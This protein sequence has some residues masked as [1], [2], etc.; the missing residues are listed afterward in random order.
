MP[1]KKYAIGVDIGGTH[2]TSAAVDLEKKMFVAD[3]LFHHKVNAHDQPDPILT[4]W[5]STIQ[6][7]IKCV[8]EDQL[9]GVGIAMPGPFDYKNGISKIKGVAKYESLFDLN[10]KQAFQKRLNL[11]G[12]KIRFMNDANCFLFGES[13]VTKEAYQKIIGITIGTGFGAAFLQDRQI[14]SKGK[15]V[16]PDAEFFP[17]PF[18]EGLSEDY[19]SSRG[20]IKKYV[21]LTRD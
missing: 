16:P 19:I 7:S 18:L 6:K 10:I 14:V 3:S 15:G 5:A 12:E 11:S 1:R 8:R 13:W 21:E 9:A 2:I 4:V 17:I 20:M